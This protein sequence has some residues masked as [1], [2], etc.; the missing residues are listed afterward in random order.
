MQGNPPAF[1]GFF[2]CPIAGYFLAM[3]FSLIPRWFTKFLQPSPTHRRNVVHRGPWTFLPILDSGL[4]VAFLLQ[5]LEVL[6][7]PPF[8][9]IDV[10]ESFV[11]S[12][13]RDPIPMGFDEGQYQA[14]VVVG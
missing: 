14:V 3:L 12:P 5:P 9:I 8:R 4:D 2:F 10:L 7:Q 13:A 11:E 1:L 6:V